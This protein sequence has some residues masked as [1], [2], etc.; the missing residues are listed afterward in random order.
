MQ[1]IRLI[2]RDTDISK[3]K[4]RQMDWDTVINRKPYFVV[5]IEGYIHTIYGLIQEMKN[6][7]VRILF[8]SMENL[9]VGA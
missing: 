7:V 5:L 9:Y 6:Q 4:M 8:N 1:S 3:L 2:D